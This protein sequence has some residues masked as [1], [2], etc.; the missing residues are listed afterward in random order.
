MGKLNVVMLRYLARDHFRVLTAV[1]SG[2]AALVVR[3]AARPAEL[4]RGW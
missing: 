3:P 4:S 1:R 2:L